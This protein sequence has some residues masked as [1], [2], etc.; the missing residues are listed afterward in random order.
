MNNGFTVTDPCPSSLP[1]QTAVRVAAVLD[2]L[3]FATKIRSTAAALG[4]DVGVVRT[5]EELTALLNQTKAAA[6]LVDLNMSGGQAIPAIRA[7]LAHRPR[8]E[9]TAFVSHVDRDL[10]NQAREAGADRVLPRSR[11]TAD[12]PSILQRACANH[13]P[14]EGAIYSL[15]H[16]APAP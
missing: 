12:L 7:A 1:S 15:E 10:A 13:L 2:D 6:V 14:A 3:I 5:A 9:V 11:F 4:M 16:R 8:P